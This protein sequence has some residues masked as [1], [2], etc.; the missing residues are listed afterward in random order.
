M[1]AGEAA[2]LAHLAE[3]ATE[4]AH[5]WRL[6]RADGLVLGFTDHDANLAFEGTV[7]R[8]STALGAG[9]L[10]RGNGLSV[11]NAAAFGALSDAAITE[12]DI[13]AGRWD[14]AEVVLWQVHWRD[15]AARRVLFR[16]TLGEVTRRDGAFEAELRS[17]A[18][19]LGRTRGRAY[20]RRCDASLGD[21]ACKVA[22]DQPAYAAEVALAGVAGPRALA[23][24]ALPGFP[25]GWFTFGRVVLLSGAAAGL[26][27]RVA[28]D[29]AVEDGRALT[30]WEDLAV[31]PQ[32]GD[33]LR[34]IAGCDKRAETCRV[35]FD[36]YMNFRGFPHMPGEDWLVSYPVRGNDNSGGKLKT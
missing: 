29:G 16:G 23:L 22:L 3:G 7:F 32:P 10:E 6:A 5:C 33:M 4:V 8:A 27:G 30:L 9:A 14:G 13:A 35:K 12:A 11:D 28:T 15:L 24:P 20:Q 19:A 31:L 26:S 36:N 21:G 34:V 1:S 18:E 17:L 25:E 2:L